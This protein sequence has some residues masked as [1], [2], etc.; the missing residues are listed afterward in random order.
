MDCNALFSEIFQKTGFCD[1]VNA[2]DTR[3][4]ISRE[5]VLL[6]TYEAFCTDYDKNLNVE[7]EVFVNY[8]FDL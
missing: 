4:T 6:F 1:F 5:L 2:I 7:N 8:I 3:A